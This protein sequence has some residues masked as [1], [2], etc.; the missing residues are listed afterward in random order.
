MSVTIIIAIV[1]LAIIAGLVA[2]ALYKA[3]FRL[4]E[5]RVKLGLAEAREQ[6]G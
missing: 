4:E 6:K 5:L 2:L 3:G 1:I